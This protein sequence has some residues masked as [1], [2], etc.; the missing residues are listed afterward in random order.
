MKRISIFVLTLAAWGRIITG[1]VAA[2]SGESLRIQLGSLGGIALQTSQV[3]SPGQPRLALEDVFLEVGGG[4][5]AGLRIH[6]RN[7]AAHGGVSSNSGF[8]I[9]RDALIGARPGS[10]IEKMLDTNRKAIATADWLIVR[11]APRPRIPAI[12]FRALRPA[13]DRTIGQVLQ[14]MSGTF[15]MTAE[16]IKLQFQTAA[17]PLDRRLPAQR[18]AATADEEESS[19]PAGMSNQQAADRSEPDL[20]VSADQP[21]PLTDSHIG[22]A[23]KD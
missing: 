19:P 4:W 22:Q 5:L 14:P 13:A 18:S 3:A 2:E 16:A 8:V 21:D 12:E 20:A 9:L 7:G 17:V 11:A 15:E 1:P 23:P 6:A 10:L